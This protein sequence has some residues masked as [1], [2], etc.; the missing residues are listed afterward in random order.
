MMNCL[1]DEQENEGWNA[2]AQDRQ[3]GND[4][5][6]FHGKPPLRFVPN[7]T[8]S[9]SLRLVKYNSAGI[10]SFGWE[11]HPM[12][13]VADLARYYP[14]PM[15]GTLHWVILGVYAPNKKPAGDASRLRICNRE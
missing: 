4:Q 10:L 6:A 1:A 11:K 9:L 13:L 12:D 15:P 7:I 5:Y 2:K 14:H 3:K 8:N